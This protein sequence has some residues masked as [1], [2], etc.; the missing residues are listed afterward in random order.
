M[1]AKKYR[2]KDPGRPLILVR[3]AT[4]HDISKILR[5]LKM[6]ASEEVYLG[7]EKVTPRH[8]RG[9]LDQ[10]RDKKSLTIV[11][12]VE[13]DIVGSLTLRQSGLK[14][15]R[16][17]RELGMLVIEGYREIGVGRALMDYALKW[18]ENEKIVEKL[19]LGVFSTNRRAFQ[20]YKHFGFR[21]EGVLKR[22]HIL[23]GKYADEIRMGL[24][25]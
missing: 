24:F 18:A 13:G 8:R 1:D 10:I 5:N 14:K 21:V 11:A 4:T 25:L 17:V 19:V 12:Q 3:K 7:T 16:H 22:Q 9:T 2:S 6:V 23:K 15:M 20:L